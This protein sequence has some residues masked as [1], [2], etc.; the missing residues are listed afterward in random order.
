[1]IGQI[2]IDG[3]FVRWIEKE[4]EKTNLSLSGDFFHETSLSLLCG[5]YRSCSSL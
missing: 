2:C 1:M 4:N 5:L 3:E